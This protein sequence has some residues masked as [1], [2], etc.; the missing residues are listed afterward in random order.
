[1]VNLTAAFSRGREYFLMFPW[2][3]GG[4]LRDFWE[5]FTHPDD[6]HMADAIHQTILQ[7]RGLAAAL[8][9]LHY[10]SS[11]TEGEGI[12]RHGDLKP[13]N[14][15]RFN[16]TTL[17]GTLKISD[18]GSARRYKVRTRT[19][20]RSSTTTFG[21]LQYEAP[22][23]ITNRQQARSRLNDI[24]SFGCIALE[25]VIWLL[26]GHEG[27]LN[28][29]DKLDEGNLM[30]SSFFQVKKSGA[31][32]STTIHPVVKTWIDFIL[33]KDPECAAHSAIKDLVILIQD[34]LLVELRQATSEVITAGTA[35]EDPDH[36]TG[37][38]LVIRAK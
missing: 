11:D 20:R 26:Y 27:Q 3:D 14:I 15:L 24:W 22:E 16:D 13:E 18:M 25:H 23:I 6:L 8:D 35:P 21:T 19:R 38:S 10:P 7:L 5:R 28:F 29:Y 37:L 9:A 4:N 36:G 2:A 17:L 32:F 30:R 33:L 34:K 31:Q 1:M 12:F